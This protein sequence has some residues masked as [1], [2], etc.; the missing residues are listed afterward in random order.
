[1]NAGKET[2]TY[3]FIIAYHV[4][5]EPSDWLETALRSQFLLPE[6]VTPSGDQIPIV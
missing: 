6:G 1:M 3:L 2:V 4:T 5:F